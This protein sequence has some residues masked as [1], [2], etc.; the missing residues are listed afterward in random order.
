[1][2]YSQRLNSLPPYLFAGLEEKTEELRRQGVDMINLGIGDP[3][4]QPPKF[5][6]DALKL[7]L[8]DPDAHLYS[9]SRGNKEVC[10]GIAEWFRGRFKVELDPD[11]EIVVT[12][13]S[14]EGLAN[15][16]R[17]IVNP[18]DKVG[19]PDPGYP[20]YG[21]AASVMN[22]GVV[23]PIPL[24]PEDGFLPRLDDLE[25]C[26]L[27]FINYPNN[28]TGALAN[29]DFYERLAF[30]MDEHPDTVVAHDSAYSEM[31]FDQATQ[32]SILEFTRNAIEFHS[33]SKTFN[34]TGYRMGFA[35]GRREYI[36]GLVK[37]KTQLD[38]GAPLFIQRAAVDSLKTYNGPIP[39]AEVLECHKIYARRKKLVERGLTELGYQ[40]FPSL[41]TFYV[42]FRI[43]GDEDVWLERAL[44][45]GVVITPGMGFGQYGRGFAR[46][47]VTV[48]E[49]RLIE[50][51]ERIREI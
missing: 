5:L 43:P 45:L 7:H 39:P 11:T 30:W 12:I 2:I 41:A 13:G 34:A 22:E 36:D 10:K 46:I 29:R 15:F 8:N 17:A 35:V 47:A 31:T 37:V 24:L 40:V 25:G 32:P 38:S 26:R 14:K 4:L 19:V 51:I 9:T 44:N 3:D 16:S 18:G 21:N 23:K 48:P 6:I 50:A 1:M 20:V 28:P 49:E 27:V 42:W 33:I